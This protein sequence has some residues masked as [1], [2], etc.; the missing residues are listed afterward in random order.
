MGEAENDLKEQS[1]VG[2]PSQVVNGNA[3]YGLSVF[4]N[5]SAKCYGFIA[6]SLSVNTN[7]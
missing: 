3:S 4:C 7:N 6:Y 2:F 5:S 1:A